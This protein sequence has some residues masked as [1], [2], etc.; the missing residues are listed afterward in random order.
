M[1]SGVGKE[2]ENAGKI[3]SVDLLGSVGLLLYYT[4]PKKGNSNF[5]RRGPLLRNASRV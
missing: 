5:K 1:V 4:G 3:L 2:G